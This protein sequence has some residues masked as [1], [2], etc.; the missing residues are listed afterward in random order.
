MRFR[1]TIEDMKTMSDAE[2]LRGLINER[3]GDLNPYTPFA[4]RLTQIADKLDK[5]IQAEQEA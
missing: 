2:I 3:K 5:E 1:W 4:K